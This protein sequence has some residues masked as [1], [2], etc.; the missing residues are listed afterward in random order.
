[1]STFFPGLQPLFYDV[2]SMITTTTREVFLSCCSFKKKNISLKDCDFERHSSDFFYCDICP[3]MDTGLIAV[4][5][6]EY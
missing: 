4:Y 5:L 3:L 2:I 1:M 6:H